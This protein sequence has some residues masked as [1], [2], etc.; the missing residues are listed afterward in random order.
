MVVRY[1]YDAWGKPSVRQDDSGI[2]LALANPYL[3]RSYYYDWE[4]GKYYLQSR[5]YDPVTGRFIN[6]DEAMYVTAMLEGSFLNLY[7]YCDNQP[8]FDTDNDGCLS[9]GQLKK[10]IKNVVNNIKTFFLN[11]ID[12]V[13]QKFQSF[14]SKT[15]SRLNNGYLTIRTAYIG[16]FIDAVI[17]TIMGVVKGAALSFGLKFFQMYWKVRKATALRDFVKNTVIPMLKNID[18]VIHNFLEYLKRRFALQLAITISK[19]KLENSILG[20]FVA[21]RW[22]S[23]FS[24]IG[25]FV[26]AILDILDGRFDDVLSI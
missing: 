23:A 18:W 7:T 11:I 24:S 25:S 9:F 26:A 21:W 8:S 16:Y 5:Y 3:Y 20:G 22:I 12:Y 10:A 17:N 2:F 4:I 6:A 1:S 13:K 19:G 15:S 14:I